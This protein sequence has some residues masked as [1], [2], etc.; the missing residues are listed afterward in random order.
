MNW[1]GR[2]EIGLPRIQTVRKRL[3]LLQTDRECR[4]F[5][6][7]EIE[8]HRLRLRNEAPE[9]GAKLVER[10]MV[11]GDIIQDCDTGLEKRNRA[12]T[13]IQLTHK[14]L[15]LANLGAGKR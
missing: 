11:Q 4:C 3:P 14:N 7:I 13:L 5:C 15:A 12:V 2:K 10:F 8:H 1:R 6:V 9:E